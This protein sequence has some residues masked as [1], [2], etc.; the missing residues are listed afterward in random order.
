M[1]GSL[2]VS[3]EAREDPP[4]GVPVQAAGRRH[5]DQL[6]VNDLG[7]SWNVIEVF[8]SRFAP[9]HIAETTTSRIAGVCA[10]RHVCL[11]VTVTA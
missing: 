2:L 3:E 4:D 1:L 5:D 7:F 10:I 9:C 6:A 8:H 11:D